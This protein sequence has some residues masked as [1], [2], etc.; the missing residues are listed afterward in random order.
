MS[1]TELAFTSAVAGLT[2]STPYGWV[3]VGIAGVF[4]LFGTIAFIAHE[5]GKTERARIKKRNAVYLDKRG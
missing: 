3:A 5:E 1:A 2:F 4:G